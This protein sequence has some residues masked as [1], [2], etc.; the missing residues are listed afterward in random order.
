MRHNDGVDRLLAAILA[1]RCLSTCSIK[2]T[3]VIEQRRKRALIWTLGIAKL[4]S[5]DNLP[6]I[7][8]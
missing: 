6:Q 8:K 4:Q 7:L 2:W 3:D 5:L 1:R